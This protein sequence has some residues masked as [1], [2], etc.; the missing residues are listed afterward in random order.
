MRSFSLR[1][2]T[3]GSACQRIRNTQTSDSASEWRS[4]IRCV[5]QMFCFGAGM[6]GVMNLLL[7][8]RLNSRDGRGTYVKIESLGGVNMVKLN[9]L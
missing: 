4:R 6:L 2:S 3:L 9:K 1:L 7:E 5:F 8:T